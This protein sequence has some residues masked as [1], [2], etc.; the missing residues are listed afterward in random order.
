MS[1]RK[2]DVGT[3]FV[4]ARECPNCG[5]TRCGEACV[6][7]CDAAHAEYE[8][9]HLRGVIDGLVSGSGTLRELVS[10]AVAAAEQAKAGGHWDARPGEAAAAALGRP[11]SFPP[12]VIEDGRAILAALDAEREAPRWQ[13]IETAPSGVWVMAWAAR[14]TYGTAAP[15]VLVT[16][17]DAWGWA[18]FDGGA[19]EPT[20]WQPLPAPP[21]VTAQREGAGGGE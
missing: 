14:G 7:N 19:V 2:Y 5:H 17:R 3:G 8:A 12:V 9:A 21:E 4:R 13:P 15:C 11:G 20:H 10:N 18:E 6:C 1:E 16:R